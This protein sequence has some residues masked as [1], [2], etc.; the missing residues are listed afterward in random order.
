MPAA[1]KIMVSASVRSSIASA[2]SMIS[3]LAPHC[4][5]PSPAVTP[6]VTSVR[7]GTTCARTKRERSRPTMSTMQ[8]PPA[9]AIS[10]DS[11]SQSMTGAL[12]VIAP[13]P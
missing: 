3:V 11:A 8:A 6:R 7:N 5:T 4:Q 1:T 2:R 9:S 13:L 10:G 12:G